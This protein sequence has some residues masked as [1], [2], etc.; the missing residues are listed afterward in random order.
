MQVP[1]NRISTFTDIFQTDICGTRP[2]MDPQWQFNSNNARPGEAPWDGQVTRNGRHAVCGAVLLD[3]FWAVT[4][5][6]CV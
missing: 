1:Y 2:A 5:A 3:K 6:H 4:A